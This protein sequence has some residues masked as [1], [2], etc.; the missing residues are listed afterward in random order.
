MYITILYSGPSKACAHALSLP[1][2]A[3]VPTY[4]GEYGSVGALEYPI[5]D[6][7]EKASLFSILMK[8]QPTRVTYKMRAQ[9]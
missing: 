4:P 7:I 3:H 1:G 6:P 5:A 2:L 9:V 8:N